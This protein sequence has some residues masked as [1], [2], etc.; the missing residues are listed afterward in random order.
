[1]VYSKI[2]KDIE[3][4]YSKKSVELYVPGANNF[5][6]VRGDDFLVDSYEESE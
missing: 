5:V 1:L 4:F 3:G 6:V 2:S